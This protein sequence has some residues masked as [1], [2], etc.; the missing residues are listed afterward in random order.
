[1]DLVY[2]GM[3][4]LQSGFLASPDVKAWYAIIQ[5]YRTHMQHRVCYLLQVSIPCN[6]ACLGS[7]EI[8]IPAPAEVT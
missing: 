4:V 8:D 2:H 7:R 3:I 1:M 5:R 6:L